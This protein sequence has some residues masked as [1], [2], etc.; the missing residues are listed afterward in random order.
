MLKQEIF[1]GKHF[2]SSTGKRAFSSVFLLTCVLFVLT[3]I[4]GLLL[5]GVSSLIKNQVHDQLFTIRYKLFGKEKISPYIVH[6]DFDETTFLDTDIDTFSYSTYAKLIRL[7]KQTGAKSIIFDMVFL[8]EEGSEKTD[9]DQMVLASSEKGSKVYYP[10][11]LRPHSKSQVSL[12]QFQAPPL[13][14]E[15]IFWDLSPH[16]TTIPS[17]EIGYLPYSQLVLASTGIGSIS[18]APD[19]DGVFRRLPLL[20]STPGGFV[21]GIGLRVVSEYLQVQP[22]RL[23]VSKKGYIK[24]TKA[25]FPDGQVKDITIPIDTQ[26]RTLVNYAGPWQDSFA[27]YSVK[28]LFSIADDPDLFELLKEDLADTIIIVSD[29]S[30]TSRDVGVTPLESHFPLSGV[31]ASFINSVINESFIKEIGAGYQFGINCIVILILSSLAY[32]HK[33]VPFTI[34]SFLTGVVFLL[35]GICLFLF[36]KVIINM[37][38]VLLAFVFSVGVLNLLKFIVQEREALKVQIEATRKAEMQLE[39]FL[40]VLGS[41][42]ES[43]DKC[44][45]GH[46]ERVANYSRDLAKKA[47][48]SPEKTREIYLGAMVH[49]LGKI[50]IADSILNKPGKLDS[51]EKAIIKTHPSIGK[52]LLEKIKEVKTAENIAHYHQEKYDGSGYPKGLKGEEIPIEARIVAV[53]D[54][55]DAIVA[56]RPYR[57]AMPL[58]RAMKIMRQERENSFDP[59]LF[60]LF[61]EPQSKLYLK[62]LHRSDQES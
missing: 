46:V 47:G 43:K 11:V 22:Q 21:P 28:R 35:T 51:D 33:S 31:S 42:I 59:N 27:H 8:R 20:A 44:T 17:A 14:S 54:V 12:Q 60:D 45:G 15:K 1:L 48:L 56:D 25:H 30:T 57:K 40:M 19:Q 36:A 32:F 29:I 52:E 38:T 4:G 10:V 53:A 39:N 61:M 23:E 16:I 7:L 58:E 55:W 37:G 3:W 18:A 49:D 50:G 34:Y 13:V 2:L 26:A 9:P 5:P 62:Y 6:V 41:A 24:L